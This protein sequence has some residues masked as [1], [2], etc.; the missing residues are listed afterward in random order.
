M[1]VALV[2]VGGGTGATLRWLITAWLGT[3][4]RGFPIGTTSVNVVGSFVLG[5][6]VGANVAAG[7]F[8]DEPLAVGVLGGFTTFSTWM[9][10]VDRAPTSKEKAI[11][12]G[13]PL[14][15]GMVAAFAGLVAGSALA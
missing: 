7:S 14:L 3:N 15:A 12:T 5:V 11:V 1:I 2:L 9:V 6:L 13:V 4:E 10:E 8:A